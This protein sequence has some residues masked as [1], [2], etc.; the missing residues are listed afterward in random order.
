[1]TCLGEGGRGRKR[2]VGDA[3]PGPGGLPLFFFSLN[4]MYY[5]ISIRIATHHIGV[6]PQAS[7]ISF[8]A[9][10]TPTMLT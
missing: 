6:L 10:T 7:G 9:L 3:H 8:I 4:H 2:D 5:A 1:M